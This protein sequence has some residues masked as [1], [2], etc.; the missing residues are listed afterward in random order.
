[1]SR[2]TTDRQTDRRTALIIEC[3]LPYEGGSI[4]IIAI[5]MSL[6]VVHT[7][8]MID[9]PKSMLDSARKTKSFTV[10]SFQFGDY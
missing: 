9:G 10:N 1:M 3:L 6:Y 4:I 7:T 2:H 8:N 5:N